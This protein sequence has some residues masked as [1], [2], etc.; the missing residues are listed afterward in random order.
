[1]RCPVAPATLLCPSSATRLRGLGRPACY[2]PTTIMRREWHGCS[3]I[4]L[5]AAPLRAGL[6]ICSA[7]GPALTSAAP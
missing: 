5:C 1:M 3:A 2:L 4:T 7:C 6:G